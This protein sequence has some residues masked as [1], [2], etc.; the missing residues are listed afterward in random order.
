MHK[1]DHKLFEVKFTPKL[2]RLYVELFLWLY[3][4]IYSIL[5]M[6]YKAYSCKLRL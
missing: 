2:K 4:V 1:P 3:A 5:F 6:L